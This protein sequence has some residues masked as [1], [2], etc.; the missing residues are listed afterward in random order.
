LH[1]YA[2]YNRQHLE[3]TRQELSQAFYQADASARV[4]ARVVRERDE[5]RDQLSSQR[6]ALA[7]AA[8]SAPAATEEMEVHTVFASI[9]IVVLVTRCIYMC[10]TN[11]VGFDGLQLKHSLAI[12]VG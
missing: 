7:V 8:A 1:N 5:A 2:L 9:H 12:L 10:G 4:I 11:V 3:T 6:A